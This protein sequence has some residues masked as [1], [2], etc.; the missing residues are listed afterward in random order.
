MT[1][2]NSPPPPDAKFVPSRGH[3]PCAGIRP[4]RSGAG[5]S[6]RYLR[7]AR[8]F[9]VSIESYTS[10]A[11]IWD[12]LCLYSW[13][14]NLSRG[15]ATP[16]SQDRTDRNLCRERPVLELH[17]CRV[18]LVL[19]RT[20]YLPDLP[21][22]PLQVSTNPA[23]VCVRPHNINGSRPHMSSYSVEQIFCD[24]CSLYP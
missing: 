17:Y 22:M 14:L 1:V 19:V 13:I 7:R 10:R 15:R 6:A 5:R 9:W 12:P 11:D 16:P 8:K 24:R 18:E 23:R 3:G 21:A 4:T 2:K 20:L